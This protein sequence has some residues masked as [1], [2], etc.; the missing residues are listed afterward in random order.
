MSARTFGIVAAKHT[1]AIYKPWGQSAM[2][3]LHDC[4]AGAVSDGGT[5]REFLL[6]VVPAIDMT[7]HGPPI[8]GRFGE[9]RLEGWTGVQLV[10]TSSVTVHLDEADFRAFIDVFSCKPF[11]PVIATRVAVD[12]F[13]GTP[14]VTTTYR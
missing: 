10:K 13:G 2:I 9:G 7:P 1:A 4:A 6:A 11:D 8:V 3:D 14:Y 12:H 5:L